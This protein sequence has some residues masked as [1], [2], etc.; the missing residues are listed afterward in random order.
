[1]TSTPKT[2]PLPSRRR[3]PEPTLVRGQTKAHASRADASGSSHE[4]L[5]LRAA[6]P[7]PHDRRTS[8]MSRKPLGRH[9]EFWLH[10]PTP[11][12]RCVEA[13]GLLGRSSGIRLLLLDV[14]YDASIQLRR[15]KESGSRALKA[16]NN[17]HPLAPPTQ[18]T[19]TWSAVEVS[20]HTAQKRGG[21]KP[22]H[23]SKARWLQA[24]TQL[25]TN[26]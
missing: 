21:C 1:L 8:W 11:S 3:L 6:H 22:P 5:Q 2:L 9:L 24:A 12:R 7:Q 20:N 25:T 13:E 10:Q 15:I 17:G 4:H 23:S 26:S 16:L 14:L 19:E 18:M